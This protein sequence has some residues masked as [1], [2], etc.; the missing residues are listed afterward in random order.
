MGRVL[1]VTVVNFDEVLRQS[2]AMVSRYDVKK[3]TFSGQQLFYKTELSAA[4]L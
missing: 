2:V 4:S 1:M 3:K